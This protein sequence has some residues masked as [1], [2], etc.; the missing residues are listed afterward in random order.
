MLVSPV[1]SS[2]QILKELLLKAARGEPPDK[3]E[4]DLIRNLS[5]CDARD[6]RHI[7][8]K[9]RTD[10]Q[11]FIRLYEILQKYTPKWELASKT[12]IECPTCEKGGEEGRHCEQCGSSSGR[13]RINQD[14]PIVSAVGED[15]SPVFSPKAWNSILHEHSKMGD[16]HYKNYVFPN[17]YETS[18]N[19][20]ALMAH[21]DKK[22]HALWN[23]RCLELA[24]QHP[25]E[26]D[27]SKSAILKTLD[28]RIERMNQTPRTKNAIRAMMRGKDE[29]ERAKVEDTIHN[30][31][32]LKVLKE[33]YKDHACTDVLL[34]MQGHQE[35]TGDCE[36]EGGASS[37]DCPS[38]L[39][40]KG[41]LRQSREEKMGSRHNVKEYGNLKVKLI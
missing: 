1:E 25:D 20:L 11:K 36:L 8:S 16:N 9:Y 15:G 31:N 14:E 34:A 13:G 24:K 39:E 7:L 32:R 2:W 17:R 40:S 22:V 19:V 5:N 3:D 41:S 33:Y 10:D 6:A 35:H 28:S 4:K 12:G 27:E 38:I 37:C 18:K 26:Y 21:K 23:M 30:S 29:S